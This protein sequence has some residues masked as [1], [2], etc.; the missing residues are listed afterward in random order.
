V[1]RTGRSAGQQCHTGPRGHRTPVRRRPLRP[2]WGTLVRSRTTVTAVLCLTLL[3]VGLAAP[4]TGS[5]P[6]PSGPVRSTVLTDLATESAAPAVPGYGTAAPT[7]VTSV[8]AR[9]PF[10]FSMVGLR[11]PQDV[12]AEV[13]TSVDGVD[14]GDWEP[15]TPHPDTGPDPR[16]AEAAAA[17]AVVPDDL[18]AAP[19]VWVGE[20]RHVQLRTTGGDPARADVHLLDSAGLSRSVTERAVDAVRAAWDGSGGARTAHAAVDQPEITT[21]EDWG[22]DEEIVRDEPVAAP[23]ARLGLVHH[24]AGGNGYAPDDVPAI[25]RGIQEFHV[26]GN[27][28]SDLGYNLLVDAYGGIWEGRRGGLEDAVIGAHAGGFNTGS[29]GVAVIGDFSG[30]QPPAGAVDGLAEVLAWKA[31][32]HHVDVLADVD[33][34]SLGST[35][36]AEGEEITLP[37]VSG[38]RDVSA[39][40]C[41]AGLYDLLPALAEEV[42]ERQGPVLVDDRADPDE[43]R[44]ADGRPLDG[45]IELSTRLRPAGEWELEVRDPDGDVVHA[46]EGEGETASSTWDVAGVEPADYTYTFSAGT[47]RAASGPVTV[48]LPTVDEATASP[49]TV[50][51]T[52]GD[53]LEEPVRFSAALWEGAAWTLTV[54]DPDGAEVFAADGRGEE[55][56]ATWEGPVAS[57]GVH[58]WTVA[59]DDAE[60]ASGT[61]GVDVDVLTRVGDA[62]DPS[63]ASVQ[64][65]RAAFPVEGTATRAVVAR[66]DVFADALTAGPLAG[67]EGPV[68]L[69]GPPAPQADAS[70]ALGPDVVDELTRV[71]PEGGT[72]YVLGGETALGTDVVAALGTRWQVERL[73]GPERTATAAA[74]AEVVYERTGSTRALLARAGPDDA[75]PW[76][77]ALAGGAW[78]AAAGVP[79]LLTD[80]DRLSSTADEVL[81]QQGVTETFVLG[82]PAA[83]FDPVVAGLPGATRV[84]G[85]DRAAT[86]VAVAAQLWGRSGGADGD[87]VVVAG[88]YRGDAWTLALAATPLAARNGAPLLVSGEDDLGAATT[89]YLDGLGYGAGRAASGWVLGDVDDVG[90]APADA[91]AGLLAGSTLG[92]GPV[93]DPVAGPVDGPVDG[94]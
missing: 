36:Y 69:T 58:T 50:G 52:D 2:A 45:E 30:A 31:D 92:D 60:P 76:A 66:G 54:E 81:V 42:A 61:V 24:T 73:A 33:L 38:H 3:V 18:V 84:A 55:L 46:D 15:V 51:I 57:A 80:P 75:V 25:L 63:A 83:I 28:W 32:V 64:L 13:R 1:T 56:S 35:R 41:P 67:S 44:V 74:V 23:R 27:G 86:A 49:S 68:L 14:W 91:A 59:A 82:G 43:V 7:T 34:T 26:N 12:V 78:G 47:R 70:E 93:D 48:A 87:R 65:S 11:L 77:D 6:V 79:V 90:E 4:A 62:A 53:R 22:A 39:T 37:A 85:E 40:T 17:A 21:R 5:V 8:P 10:P 71:L 9:A 19:P 89:A 20:A 16:S 88:A 29:F 72:V 94:G